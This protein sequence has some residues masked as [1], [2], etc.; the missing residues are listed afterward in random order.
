MQAVRKVKVKDREAVL[1]AAKSGKSAI[2]IARELDLDARSVNGV[3]AMWRRH[4]GL[5]PPPPPA[6]PSPEDRLKLLTKAWR[7]SDPDAEYSV[8]TASGEKVYIAAYKRHGIALR[9][10]G[11]KKPVLLPL[12]VAMHVSMKLGEMAN[13]C[14]L[15][16]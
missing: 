12:D 3:V 10:D 5:T 14:R 4:E 1:Q 9:V 13:W 8:R 6:P 16:F 7:E 11:R 15:P 2:Q